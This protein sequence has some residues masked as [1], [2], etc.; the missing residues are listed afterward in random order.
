[1]SNLLIVIGTRPEAIKLAPLILLFNNNTRYNTKILCT[2]QHINPVI[3]ILKLFNITE[4][5]MLKVIN[6]NLTNLTISIMQNVTTFITCNFTPNAIIVQGD[7]TSAYVCSLIAFYNKIKIIHIEA[8]LRTHDILNPYPEEFNRKSIDIIADLN[9]CTTDIALNNLI[10]EHIDTKK[11]YHVGNIIN[12]SL[13][14]IINKYNIVPHD[15]KYIIITCH[16]RENWDSKLTELCI[17]INNII[18]LYDYQFLFIAHPNPYIKNIIHKYV[19]NKKCIILDPLPYNI[20]VEKLLSARL[21]I[22]D[23]G[24]IQEEACILNIPTF[25][26]RKSTERIDGLDN[27]LKIVYDIDSL[28]VEINNELNN[29]LN[30]MN[31]VT[32][33][34]V[35]NINV[36]QKI[37][38]IIDETF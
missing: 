20:F 26:Y 31:N 38:D 34:C 6:D 22:T 18:D 21:I 7:T 37:I 15:K 19:T 33:N 11:C 24:G 17:F 3:E 10:N 36:S 1:M 30:N 32:N 5:E 4:Y 28:Y 23:S 16:R 12:D 8:G 25:V 27:F 35:S 29:E 9:F 14:Y 2:G 13:Y